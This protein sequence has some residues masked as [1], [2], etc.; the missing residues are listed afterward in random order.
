MENTPKS[1]VVLIH[2]PVYDNEAVFE[3]LQKGINLLG[4]LEAFVQ[5]DEKILLK[6]NLLRKAAPE[7]A[8]TTHPTVFRAIAKLL[9]EQGYSNLL[10]GDSPGSVMTPFKVAQAAGLK[11]AADEFNLLE[12]DFM[13]GV[14]IDFPEGKAVKSFSICKGVV[15]ADA[16]I[17]LCKM[18]THALVRVTGAVKNTYGCV[19]GFNKGAGHAKYPDADNFSKMLADLN[20]LV[21][22]K[23]HIMD[24]IMAMEGNGPGSGDP[25]PMNVLL[26]SADPVALDS[27]FCHLVAL[28]PQRVPTN[29]YAEIYGVGKSHSKD[30]EVVTEDGVI[31]CEEA[32]AKYGNPK[33]NVNRGELKKENPGKKG[34]KPHIVKE[35]CIK[36]GICV[37]IC[38][39]EEKAL[40]MDKKAGT[41][42]QYDYDKCIRCYC[43]Q[44]M[45]PQKA[46]EVKT[47]LMVRLLGTKVKSKR[48]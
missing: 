23:L 24:G 37:D 36:C 15:D 42:P 41:I 8:V 21:K 14:K 35:K 30:I 11:P 10:Y 9:R 47:P 40:S 18:K 28:D 12:G 44:E 32:F 26:I 45:C 5:K 29:V 43:C 25:T 16:I 6:P 46:I 4:G 48:K 27:V 39:V 34:R 38:P 2:C 17:N 20:V 19:S 1:K 3:A 22:P 33:F 13:N 31:T 7:Q